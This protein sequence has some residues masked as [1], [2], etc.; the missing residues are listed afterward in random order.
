MTALAAFDDGGGPMLYAAGSFFEADGQSAEGIARWTGSAWQP[1]NPGVSGGIDAMI[2]FHNGTE[3]V[4][5][6]GGA[7]SSAGAT[8]VNDV[9]AWN[10]SSWQAMGDPGASISE[11]RLFDDG[12]GSALYAGRFVFNPGALPVATAVR[13]DGTNWQDVGTPHQD[14]FSQTVALEGFFNNGE[15]SLFAGGF[16]DRAGDETSSDFGSYTCPGVFIFGDGFESGTVDRWS[17]AFP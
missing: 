3:P 14:R 16:F 6:V 15:L 4:L 10:G 9:A 12:G 17:S 1:L 7:F 13:W 11:L 8:P 2:P 5:V